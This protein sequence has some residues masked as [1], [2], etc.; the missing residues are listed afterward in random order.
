MSR[1]GDP[2]FMKKVTGSVHFILTFLDENHHY[3]LNKQNLRYIEL[4]L[5]DRQILGYS[6]NN[7]S[8]KILTQ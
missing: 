1:Y 8:K 7:A 4:R 6:P 3:A 5:A 2:I